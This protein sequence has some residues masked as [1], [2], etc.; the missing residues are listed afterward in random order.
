MTE[1]LSAHKTDFEEVVYKRIGF[2][3]F[4]DPTDRSNFS[5]TLFYM[6]QALTNLNKTRVVI[7]GQGRHKNIHPSVNIVFKGIHKIAFKCFK[8]SKNIKFKIE[9]H[10][11]K[12]YITYV[13][14]E[15]KTKTFDFVIAPV[16]SR[17]VAELDLTG[18][19]LIFATDTTPH[20]I[21]TSPEYSESLSK[22]DFEAENSCIQQCYRAFYSSH[23]MAEK[24]KKE[25][26][27]IA[28]I[29]KKV[30]VARFG[31][32][33]D[34]PPKI[35]THKPGLSSLNILFVGKDWGRKGGEIAFDTV[36]SLRKQGYNANLTILG[37]HPKHLAAHNFC[38]IIPFIDKNI[39]KQQAQYFELLS[40]SHFLLLPTRA[41]CTPMVIAEANAFA[42][43]VIATS[44][45][46]IASLLENGI[47][48]QL[49]KVEDQGAEY[50]SAIIESITSEKQYHD[51]SVSS[52]N[53]YQSHLTW[54]AWAETICRT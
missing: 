38:T 16:G 46:G 22:Q 49:M 51:L 24:A 36:S 4:E 9:E 18:H 35:A 31:L 53:F 26:S 13:Q 19:R 39:P 33:L 15:L 30:F 47:N 41:D 11:K 37:C 32:N 8:I 1:N 29:K 50:A 48:G 44:V 14:K 40:K 45:G 42:T 17:I 43:P 6:H 10:K 25:F 21:N 5:G 34:K 3:S 28:K 52:F 7:L 27:H 2:I 12:R 20:Y 54:E 23:F